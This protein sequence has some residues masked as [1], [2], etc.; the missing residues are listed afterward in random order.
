[1]Q[2]A[3]ML[4][5]DIATCLHDGTVMQPHRSLLPFRLA[6]DLV[7]LKTS[8]SVLSQDAMQYIIEPYVFASM[9]NVPCNPL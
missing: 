6:N 9:L 4:R 8:R 2:Q 5:H 1:M 7:F 3:M